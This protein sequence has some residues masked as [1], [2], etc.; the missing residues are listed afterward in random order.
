MP[1][2]GKRSTDN[3]NTL[4]ERLARVLER[5]IKTGPDFTII[6]GHRGEFDQNKAYSEGFSKARWPLS[7]HNTS[8]S[9]AADLLP[10]GGSSAWSDD[11]RFAL[12]A[13]WVLKCAE[14]EGVTLRW[15]GDW[16]RSWRASVASGFF[17]GAHFEIVEDD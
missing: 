17:D 5:A 8:P 15:G 14:E 2:F 9:L 7:K 11:M 13:G 4:D 3:L 16:N 10:Y 6:A 12:M 1:K